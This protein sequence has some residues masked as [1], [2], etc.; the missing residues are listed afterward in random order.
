M[1]AP[2][3]IWH[4]GKREIASVV[5]SRLGRPKQ[6]IE[7]FCGG[8]AVLLAA[9]APALLEVIGDLN[10]FVANFWRAVKHQPGAV[11]E[12]AG[13]PVSHIDLTARHGWL[14]EQRNRLADG[15]SDPDWP[16]DAKA[17]GW[18]LWGQNAWIGTGWCTWDGDGN[19]GDKIPCITN[20]GNGIHAG[21]GR[22][23][24]GA[25]LAR[26]GAMAHKKISELTKR[27][28]RVVIIH[29]DWTRGLNHTYGG[30]NTAVFLDPPYRGYD[31]PYG[32]EPVADAVEAWARDH[33]HLRIALCGYVGDYNLPGWELVRWTRIRAAH[34]GKTRD[35]ECIWFSPAC[36]KQATLF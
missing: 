31:A 7:P 19:C 6:Y 32:T 8:C 36:E 26:A 21:Q 34:G 18:W 12:A 35:N 10:G 11:I 14:L 24:D 3:F 20:G 9:P 17:A 23:A 2:P 25:F 13:Y 27:L 5:W 33:R 1:I 29:G 16:G 30:D 22:T 15:L 28:S 4:G